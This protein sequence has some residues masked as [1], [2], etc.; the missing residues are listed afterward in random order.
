VD[1]SWS[2]SPPPDQELT[3]TG[4]PVLNATTASAATIY[5]TPASVSLLASR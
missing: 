1:R 3:T 2:P 4:T 5:P